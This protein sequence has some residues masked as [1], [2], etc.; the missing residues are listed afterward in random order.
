[1]AFQIYGRYQWFHFHRKFWEANISK[2]P[3]FRRLIEEM[4]N[5]VSYAF[6]SAKP[7]QPV[8]IDWD[9]E[10]DRI[11]IAEEELQGWAFLSVVRQPDL[12]P[13]PIND[14]AAN[15]EV[16]RRVSKEK[17]GQVFMQIVRA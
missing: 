7:R 1:M 11:D 14:L 17:F 9:A 12:F 3:L 10:F 13:H 5:H 2:D 15:R 4:I 6:T 16:L 8:P